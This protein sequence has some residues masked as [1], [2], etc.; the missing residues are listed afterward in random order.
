MTLEMMILVSTVVEKVAHN[1][2]L[3]L[4]L[5]QKNVQYVMRSA[6]RVIIRCFIVATVHTLFTDVDNK[7]I[8][9]SFMLYST[10]DV[11]KPFQH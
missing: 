8:L 1:A 9:Y 11:R 3:V 6:I 2:N 4:D 10:S 7:L 5:S